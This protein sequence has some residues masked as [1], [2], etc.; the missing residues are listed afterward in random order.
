MGHPM[1]RVTKK[2]SG[3]EHE[4]VSPGLAR[5]DSVPA[6]D[7]RCLSA[8][9]IGYTAPVENGQFISFVRVIL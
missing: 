7:Q 5:G 2:E 4:L 6:L 8:F 1:T 9:E 3:K